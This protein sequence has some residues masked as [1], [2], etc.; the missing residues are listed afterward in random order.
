MY[1]D[2]S[3]DEYRQ[4]FA[5][6]DLDD[7]QLIDVREDDEY[8][9][10]HLPGA[11]NI[12]LSEFMARVDEIDEDLPVLL[13]CNTGVRSAQA[14]MYLASLGYDQLYNLEDGTKGWREKGYRVDRSQDF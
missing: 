12:P 7:Y 6:D 14:A 5:D 11:I 3:S 4:Q 2:L 8:A 10:A 1:T 9:E 13:V